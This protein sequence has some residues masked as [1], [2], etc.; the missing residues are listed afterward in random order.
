VL[1]S[2]EVNSFLF[3]EHDLVIPE[4][5]IPENLKNLNSSEQSPNPLG[6]RQNFICAEFAISENTVHERD[7]N[8]AN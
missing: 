3:K 4:I 5:K 7:R 2:S 1:R 8:L 6:I